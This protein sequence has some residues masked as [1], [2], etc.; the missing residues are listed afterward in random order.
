[1]PIGGARNGGAGL[2][3]HI[4]T[5]SSSVRSDVVPTEITAQS[6]TSNLEA[7]SEAIFAGGDH[8]KQSLIVRNRLASKRHGESGP[9]CVRRGRHRLGTG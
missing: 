4:T 8:R 9:P 1:M 3:I 2:E 5:G 6:H 7:G